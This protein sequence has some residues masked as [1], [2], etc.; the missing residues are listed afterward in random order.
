MPH[1]QS[2][3][4]HSYLQALTKCRSM[5]SCTLMKNLQLASSG[6]SELTKASCWSPTAFRCK[7]TQTLL[8]PGQSAYLPFH[9][10]CWRLVIHLQPALRLLLSAFEAQDGQAEGRG[11][12]AVWCGRAWAARAGHAKVG[13]RGRHRLQAVVGEEF[14]NQWG[15]RD[16]IDGV[17]G[18]G[19]PATKAGWLDHCK[20]T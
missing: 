13:L 10:G 16:P 12:S 17:P 8:R 6:Y 9:P 19:K 7:I 3:L 15:V 5:A 4:T 2:S 20:F 18:H 1:V 11:G 14:G